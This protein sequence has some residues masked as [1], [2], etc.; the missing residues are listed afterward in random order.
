M[1]LL[2][3]VNPAKIWWPTGILGEGEQSR[4]HLPYPCRKPTQNIAEREV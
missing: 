4:L 2:D 1:T 3:D